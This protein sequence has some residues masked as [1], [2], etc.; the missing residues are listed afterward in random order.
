M[1]IQNRPNR[2]P[3]T[4]AAAQPSQPPPNPQPV[5]AKASPGRATPSYQIRRE[6][7]AAPG[8]PVL[9]TYCGLAHCVNPGKL[10]IPASRQHHTTYPVRRPRPFRRPRVAHQTAHLRAVHTLCAVRALSAGVPFSVKRSNLLSSPRRLYPSPRRKPDPSLPQTAGAFLYR[11]SGIVIPAQ[12]GIY[13][14]R[15]GGSPANPL[16]IVDILPFTP[17]PVPLPRRKPESIR[18][19]NGR[20]LPLSSFVVAS[21]LRIGQSAG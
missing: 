9:P 5:A 11:H 10:T 1:D 2:R 17:A 21:A 14:A 12:A 16:D 3:T 6:T 8:I 7:G 13:P 15:S 18:A 20:R 19:P 4:L